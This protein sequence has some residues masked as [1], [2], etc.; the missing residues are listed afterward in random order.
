MY[1]TPQEIDP[2]FQ[3]IQQQLDPNRVF[4]FEQAPYTPDAEAFQAP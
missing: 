4:G 2:A 3:A 1:Y